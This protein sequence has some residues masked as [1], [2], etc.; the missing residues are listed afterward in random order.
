MSTDDHAS[1]GGEER[2]TPAAI[3]QRMR[4]APLGGGWVLVI[5]ATV[6]VVLFGLGTWV[7]L[8]PLQVVL[9]DP[10]DHEAVHAIGERFRARWPQAPGPPE[11]Y[12]AEARALQRDGDPAA[13]AR[14]LAMAIALDPDQSEAFLRLSILD[15]RGEADGLLVPG[16]S[17]A[18]VA[19]MD[20]TD[21]D[22]PLLP[23]ARAWRALAAGGPEDAASMTGEGRSEPELLWARLRAHRALG[24]PE[25]PDARALLESWP[26]HP[27]ACEDGPRAALRAGD[28]Y[29][30]ERL[31]ET[32]RAGPAAAIAGRVLADVRRRSGRLDAAREA[33]AS[34]GLMLHAGR[35]ALSAG[36]P[37]TVEER[38]AMAGPGPAAAVLQAW[39]A[40]AEGDARLLAMAVERLPEGE[41]PELAVT[42]A[43]AALWSGD[44][45]VAE[46]ILAG[47][48]G[49]RAA[50]LRAQLPGAAAADVA[51][52]RTA[53]PALPGGGDPVAT[54]LLLGASDHAIPTRLLLEVGRGIGSP[55]AEKG[56][57]V[58]SDARAGTLLR[59][60]DGRQLPAASGAGGAGGDAVDAALE[61]ARALE[62]GRDP[63][64]ALERLRA[65]APDLVMTDV[66]EARA[67]PDATGCRAALARSSA[68]MPGLAGLDRERYLCA[69]RSEPAPPR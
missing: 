27:E 36:L 16:E 56:L 5:V 30:A 24:Q 67:A 25:G 38:A 4:P 15:A 22:A 48:D 63:G 39:T 10:S 1:E 7:G 50:V 23:A 28:L 14:R 20:V 26:G 54:H 47:T 37:L 9:S 55:L 18:L 69:V 43:A 17:D 13:A 51:A 60:L 6:L 59:W 68:R 66:L 58:P 3:R 8:A 65:V 29:E 42:R 21:P 44:V 52:A 40:M 61:V 46:Q 2:R 35:V 11:R 64:E 32:C 53:W 49:P 33:Y 41:A 31:A 12:L 45:E 34:G 62:D 57:W 19:V